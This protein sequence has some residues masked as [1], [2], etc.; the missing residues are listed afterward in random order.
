MEKKIV[1][2]YRLNRISSLMAKEFGTI[3]KGEED[4]DPYWRLLFS[5]ESN[6]LKL[7]RENPLFTGS[8]AIKAVKMSLLVIDGYIREIEYDYSRFANE[9][10]QSFMHVMLMA[11]DPFT[12]PE[13]K[14]NIMK[15]RNAFNAT[16]YFELPIKCLL[17]IEKSIQLWTGDFG[18]NGY[19]QFLEKTL[20]D[21]IKSDN[22][23]NFVVEIKEKLTRA[24][25]M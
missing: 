19:F 8:W 7:H 12:N 11:V 14:K 9:A 25:R 15:D 3:P 13:I 18:E 5:I 4:E 22:K 2:A 6:L 10:N 23:M 17:R 16:E 20:G 21:N 24:F 1:D